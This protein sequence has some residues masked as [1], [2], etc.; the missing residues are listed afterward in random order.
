[1]KHNKGEMKSLFVILFCW[2]LVLITITFPFF[3]LKVKASEFPSGLLYV[4]GT[5]VTEENA[6]DIL[7]DGKASFDL[8]SYTLYLNGT[9]DVINLYEKSIIW[10]NLDALNIVL[11]EDTV[12]NKDEAT[13]GIN[14]AKHDSVNKIDL[15]GFD[16]TI[17]IGNKDG[18]SIRNENSFGIRFDDN[19]LTITGKSLDDIL[20]VCAGP[21]AGD[22]SCGISNEINAKKGELNINSIALRSLGNNSFASAGV[23]VQM[24]KLNIAGGDIYAG[25]TGE[26]NY[27]YG[28]NVHNGGYE[29]CISECAKVEVCLNIIDP[30][31]DSTGAGINASKLTVSGNSSLYV[32][33]KGG[34]LD[35]IQI[36][37]EMYVK[38][39]S[40]IEIDNSFSN[41]EALKFMNGA[42]KKFNFESGSIEII[43]GNLKR[44]IFNDIASLSTADESECIIA[45]GYAIYMWDSEDNTNYTKLSRDV[46]SSFFKI[47]THVCNK[48][49]IKA[50]DTHEYICDLA[51]NNH[52]CKYCDI[53]NNHDYDILITKATT[54]KDG[55]L[56][57]QCKEEGCK[58]IKST[59]KIAKI[60]EV[61]LANTSYVYTG[62]ALKPA[63][64]VKDSAG[65][66]IDSSNYTVAYSNNKAVGTAT[67][68]VTFKGNYSGSK[69]LTF[70]IK[71]K[72][73]TIKTLAASDK[74]ATLTWDKGA[75]G[76][77]GYVIYRATSKNGTY[78]KVSTVKKLATVTY[79]DKSLEAGKTYYYK[80]RAYTTIDGKNVYGDYSAIK[81]VKTYSNTESFVARI[82]TKALGRDPEAGGLQYWT[83]EINAKSK[84]PV[85]VAELFIFS[86]EFSDKKL[87]DTE[88]I[89]VLYRTFMGREY[90]QGGLEYWL[91]QMKAGKSR[92]EVLE[93]FAGCKEFQDIIKS[94]GL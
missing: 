48:L 41:M 78:S 72:K 49:V 87:N 7:G 88:Y 8:S 73:V 36:I 52:R 69:S 31:S 23:R 70:T 94:F 29:V 30:N 92:K 89:K 11:Q 79:S 5:E 24:G 40:H 74:G 34:N 50:D 19:S 80:V 9:P 56:V 68:K 14:F 84:T 77:T 16:L 6:G 17:K 22:W 54:S 59:T 42:A 53:T 86:Q 66:S 47:S 76:T 38:E 64:T 1:M 62:S 35:G 26:S 61:K 55:L 3:T 2:S 25:T 63:V 60:S 71:P 65:K 90:D 12:L 85:E 33:A 28:I 27:N 46:I 32:K 57:E 83:G 13:I 4:Y 20:D 75:T 82:Y 93:S 39:N 81:S 21:T 45:Q 15:N 44:A 67:A 51:N 43:S 18:E 37:Y 58:Y 91:S 10:S